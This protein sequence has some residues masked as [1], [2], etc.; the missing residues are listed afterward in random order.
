MLHR[1]SKKSS[2]SS[3]KDDSRGLKKNKHFLQKYPINIKTICI[4]GIVLFILYA[5]I[6]MVMNNYEDYYKCSSVTIVS[7]LHD[8]TPATMISDPQQFTL[9]WTALMSWAQLIRGQNIIIF[10]DTEESCNFISSHIRNIQ[11][12]TIT[13]WNK[14]YNKP[15]LNCIFHQAHQHSVTDTMI[16][17]NGDIIIT[18]HLIS[19]I[20]YTRSNYDK[21]MLVGRR[22]NIDMSLTKLNEQHTNTYLPY[23]IEMCKQYGQ[24]HTGYGID[25][26]VYSKKII[27][28]K[29]F[30]PFLAGVYRW[31]NW[32]LSQQILDDTVTTIDIT[33][34]VLLIHQQRTRVTHHGR[35]GAPYNDQLTKQL[36]GQQYKIG[37]ID[38]VQY[39]LNGQCPDCT[40]TV[41]QNV[42]DVVLFTKRASKD[43]YLVVLTVNSGYIPLAL[44]WVCWAE[45]I[46]FIN[47]VLI[48]EDQK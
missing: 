45:R 16:Y 14:E 5:S 46:K 41:N 47:Y 4:I 39:I 15:L 3:S 18:P 44:H 43:G 12:F 22:T 19:T 11:C 21:F 20:E 42:T 40:V 28:A 32:L 6:R 37:T 35:T 10:V 2:S 25:L 30:P 38:N 9:Q 34:S 27:D 23:L 26:F 33:N 31:D 36:N 29:Q 7:L 8:M 48:A 17:I 13:C 1:S 24:L